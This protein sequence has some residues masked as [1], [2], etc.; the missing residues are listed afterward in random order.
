MKKLILSCF[1]A[2]GFAASAQV[3]GTKTIGTDYPT[4]A[5]AFTA[6]NTDGVGAG[7]ATINIPAGYTETAPSGGFNLG[8]TVLNASLSSGN[9]LV[10]QKDGSGTNPLLKANTGLGT[11]DAVVAL[12]GV[13]Y[14]T[15][16]GIDL[17]ANI[18]NADAG[19]ATVLTEYGFGLFNL[20]AADGCQYNT[21]KNSTVTFPVLKA[22][23]NNSVGVYA[24][25]SSYSNGTL[26]TVTLANATG[27]HSNNK[28]YANTIKNPYYA[29]IYF[30]SSTTATYFGTGNDIGGSSAE[31]GNVIEGFGGA[32]WATAT[33]ATVSGTGNGI[34]AQYQANANVSY[35]TITSANGYDGNIGETFN[36]TAYGIFLN[37][38]GSTITANNNTI[39]MAPMSYS[40]A[41]T[42]TG[43][44]CATATNLTANN[45][46]VTIDIPDQFN[47]NTPTIYGINGAVTTGTFT[48]TGNT[49]KSSGLGIRANVGYGISTTSTKTINITDNIITG[50]KAVNT[51]YSL[52]LGA[53]GITANILRNKVSD[54]TTTSTTG[55]T[56]HGIYVTVNTANSVVNI[57]NNVIGDLRTPAANA[58]GVSL[59]GIYFYAG[60][61]ATK[62]NVY[63][64]S[65]YLN[66]TS[67][68]T[69][70][71]ST[72]IYHVA[73]A[74]AANATL[75]LRNNIIVNLSTPN[76]TGRATALRRSAA[77]LA[78]YATTSNNNDFYVAANTNSSV[79]YDG[80]NAETLAAFQTRVTDR[81]VNSLS[82]NPVFLSTSGSSANFLKINEIHASNQAL[83]NKGA[84]VD[85]VTTD[86]A[87][88]T[89]NTTT[90]DMGAYEFTYA[91]P[92]AAPDCTTIISP[93]NLATNVA[94]GTVT[95]S[96]NPAAN[97]AGY[98]VYIGTTSGGTD[99]ANGTVTTNTSYSFASGP[100]IK[101]YVKVVPT[102]DAGDASGCTEIEFTTTYCA[103][104]ATTE[105]AH[106][107]GNISKVEFAGI[108]NDSTGNDAPYEDYTAIS[109]N[110]KKEVSFPITVKQYYY[111]ASNGYLMNVWIDYNHDGYF[112]DDEKTALT[113]GTSEFTGSVA[114]PSTALEGSTGMRVRL[115]LLNVEP[116]ACGNTAYGQ[117]EDYTI[118][119]AA[120]PTVAPDC[121]TIT[122]PANNAVGV[123]LNPVTIKW[124]V[125]ENALGYKVYVGTTS[126]GTDIVNGV[127]TANVSYN[128][129]LDANTTYYAK[130][131]PTNAIG[132]ATGC[133]EI[134]FTTGNFVYCTAAGTNANFE[135]I[136]NVTFSDIN[137]TS[138]AATGYEDFTSITGNAER[139]KS[140]HFTA[141][142][143][144]TSFSSDQVIVW[145]DYNQDG[146]FEDTGEKVLTSSVK[147]SPWEGDIVIPADAKLGNT[148]MRVRLHDSTA[149]VPNTTPCG[150]SSYGEV[151]DYTINIKEASLAVSNANADKPAVYPNPFHDV[152]KISDAANVKSVSV[153]DLSGR[154]V[155]A[156]APASELN[157]SGL[158]EGIY[159]VNLQM[160][161]G[162]V[163]SF[164][165]I[166]K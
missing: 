110:V 145:I 59:S 74:T 51:I 166:K 92:T 148:R 39:T 72:G 44:H 43:I 90:P 30:S 88:A 73:N 142:Y 100:F 18:S 26:T 23:A 149:T 128:V 77:E 107:Y 155:K 108:S 11:G 49:V 124:N 75:D 69:N 28:I 6:L 65:I 160:K 7:G 14:V 85:G 157:L 109:G 95:I 38:A 137:N 103:V 45:N 13:D 68:G 82:L 36:T 135:K 113:A 81:E 1:V 104:G 4:L 80:T 162:S 22:A 127:Q 63:Y 35:N 21:I 105:G 117:T 133:T 101:Y 84:A 118:N 15:F 34:V 106:V 52:N 87:G 123:T 61:N 161:D 86:Y 79:Y 60:T 25:P 24:V 96:W 66:G 139:E 165:V 138:T 102:N 33:T 136:S 154:K 37:G 99:V 76:G 9:P 57:I 67:T 126:G 164:K 5:D 12:K 31:T 42:V 50:L 8:S 29:G 27:T 120:A 62:Y 48:A 146:D 93:V 152:L 46:V 41:T 58:T 54:L 17:E 97:S 71:N 2:A 19:T 78:N 125:A 134:T 122:S 144:G 156:L 116:P 153:H 10:I 56:V 159:I 47:G 114:I 3:T 119:I 89:R 131:V 141:S 111:N 94:S 163:Q 16:D 129:T 158:S 64:N 143:S 112:T 140:Y 132:D 130:V 83:D 121:T 55:G 32:R 150:Y 147:V 151:E 53:T 40:S 70:F 91:A 115:N 98:K 20:V